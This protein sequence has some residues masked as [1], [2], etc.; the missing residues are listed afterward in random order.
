M[1]IINE[2]NIRVIIDFGDGSTSDDFEG[3][4]SEGFIPAE[5]YNGAKELQDKLDN[6][7][8]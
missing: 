1:K 2:D 6:L 3:C 5:I 8:F 4:F 7:P